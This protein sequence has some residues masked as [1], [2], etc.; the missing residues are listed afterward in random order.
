MKKK[1]STTF[2]VKYLM[3]L[4]ELLELTRYLQGKVGIV[5]NN[6][7]VCSSACDSEAMSSIDVCNPFVSANFIGFQPSMPAALAEAAFSCQLESV[8]AV[9]TKRRLFVD[10][11]HVECCAAEMTLAPRWKLLL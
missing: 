6:H 11:W 8:P 4:Q 9:V 7:L 3:Q 10:V 2:L 1:V 5:T